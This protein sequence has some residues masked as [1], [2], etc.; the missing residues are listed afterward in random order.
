VEVYTHFVAVRDPHSSL[1]SGYA[2]VTP[3]TITGHPLVAVACQWYD[4]LTVPP[5]PLY[6][7]TL[8]NY[9]PQSTVTC[10]L[11]WHYV[12]DSN[13]FKVLVM[14]RLWKESLLILRTESTKEI[15]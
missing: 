1:G 6:N 15:L 12:S 9:A 8:R 4:R 7:P 10:P 13:I 11:P 14:S 2:A 3:V 5:R